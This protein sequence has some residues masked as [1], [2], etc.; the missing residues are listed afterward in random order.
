MAPVNHNKLDQSKTIIQILHTILGNAYK[1]EN[2]PSLA[3]QDFGNDACVLVRYNETV[4]GA[5]TNKVKMK[6]LHPNT[7]INP[8]RTVWRT[9]FPTD[10][11]DFKVRITLSEFK[12][13]LRTDATTADGQNKVADY[14]GVK[15]LWTKRVDKSSSA[16]TSYVNL[17]KIVKMKSKTD[18]ICI[19]FWEGMHRH[20]AIMMSMLG[21][22]ITH[23]TK[24]WYKPNTLDT[25][26]FSTY[27]TRFSNP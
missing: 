24:S 5:T 17:L 20:A 18:N 21:V 10:M 4:E 26:A 12:E 6:N 22:N 11:R 23:D 7:E 2:D 14:Y 1:D 3:N 25:T 15:E 16:M 27:I 8:K 13:F 9:L 19:S